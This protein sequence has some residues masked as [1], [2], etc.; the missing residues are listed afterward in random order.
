MMFSKRFE[1]YARP[2]RLSRLLSRLKEEGKPV[3]DLTESNPTRCR[4][5]YPSGLLH[6]FSTRKNLIYKPDP[7]GSS[8]AR[9]AILAYYRRIGVFLKPEQI[10]LTA[11]SSEAYHFL[12]RLLADHNDHILMPSPGYPLMEHLA[13]LNDIQVDFFKLEYE[14][15]A[16][17]IDFDSLEKGIHSRTRAIVIIHPNNPTGSYAGVEE[18]NRLISLA[19]KHHLPIISDEVFFD[20]AYP[21]ADILPR[22]FSFNSKSLT[23]TLSGLSKM[24]CLPQMKASWLVITGPVNQ[25]RESMRRLELI[26]DAYLSV[27]TPVQNALPGILKKRNF[28]QRQVMERVLK[29]R[30]CLIRRLEKLKS[31]RLLKGEG[32]WYAVIRLPR[33]MS[34]EAWALRFLEK[35]GVLVYPGHFF[36]FQIES[37][38]VLSLLPPEPLFIRGVSKIVQRISK[39]LGDLH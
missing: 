14:G 34:D 11:S 39:E 28:I 13:R 22:S 3:I 6:A 32:G 27:N 36:D 1:P 7:R 18:Q 2:N 10:F 24:A 4:F 17:K 26:A 5:H 29:N 19:K 30:R 35:E 12:F 16:W 25:V 33:I 9:E 23:F 20:Y 31:C 8:G 21:G 15:E 37:C 38:L